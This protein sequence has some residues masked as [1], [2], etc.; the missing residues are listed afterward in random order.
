MALSFDVTFHITNETDYLQY[1][2]VLMK[3][4]KEILVFG[5]DETNKGMEAIWGQEIPKHVCYRP[6]ISDLIGMGMRIV[7]IIRCPFDAR[8]D[9]SPG[10]T[11]SRMY[12]LDRQ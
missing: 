11:F 4:G 9:Q 10:N 1:L 7:N 2:E 3:V 12:L 8:V 6:V 5:V